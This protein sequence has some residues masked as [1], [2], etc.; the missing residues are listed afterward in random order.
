MTGPTIVL[1][2]PRRN[3]WAAVEVRPD[4]T[5]RVLVAG[6]SHATARAEARAYRKR[7]AR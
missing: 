7:V 1:R 2:N 5:E 3:E 4:G 6:V